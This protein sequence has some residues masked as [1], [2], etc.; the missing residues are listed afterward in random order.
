MFRVHVV[1]SVDGCLPRRLPL[2]PE[3]GSKDTS[4]VKVIVIV[5]VRDFRVQ[6]KIPLETDLGCRTNSRVPTWKQ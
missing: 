5:V 1:G 3:F 6:G 4:R 2:L